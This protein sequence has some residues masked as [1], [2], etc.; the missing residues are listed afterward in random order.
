MDYETPQ[1]EIV[2][3]AGE[4]IQFKPAGTD[5]ASGSGKSRAMQVSPALEA[6]E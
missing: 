3:S 2:A 1:I 6:D 4:L 5:D